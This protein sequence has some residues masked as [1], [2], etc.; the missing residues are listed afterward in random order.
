MKKIRGVWLTTAAS[1]VLESK[2]NIKKAMQL[3]AEAGFNTVFPVV[4]NNG[5]T[6]YPSAVLNKNFGI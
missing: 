3:L 2:Q 4:W 6:L 5:Y 1:D